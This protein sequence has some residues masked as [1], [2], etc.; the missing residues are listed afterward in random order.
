MHAAAAYQGAA[1]SAAAGSS[2]KKAAVKKS[3]KRGGEDAA[4]EAKRLRRELAARFSHATAELQYIGFIKP[5]K[6]RRGDYVQR[7]VHMPAAGL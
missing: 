4:A 2:K 6:R 1:G 7:T 5:S 3:K